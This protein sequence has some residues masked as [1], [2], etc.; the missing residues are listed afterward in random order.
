MS[1]RRV[2]LAARLRLGMVTASGR[3]V[4]GILRPDRGTVKRG[5]G[6]VWVEFS[7]GDG[8]GGG[9]AYFPSDRVTLA[10]GEDAPEDLTMDDWEGRWW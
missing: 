8:P 1:E 10:A 7:D 2:V 6:R 3:T 9:W 4:V 5:Y